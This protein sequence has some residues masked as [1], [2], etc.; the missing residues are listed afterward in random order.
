MDDR[1]YQME[2][3]TACS[4]DALYEEVERA[5]NCSKE[6]ISISDIGSAVRNCPAISMIIKE[7]L[8]M[9]IRLPEEFDILCFKIVFPEMNYDDI[10][11]AMKHFIVDGKETSAR[12]LGNNRS[13]VCEKIKRLVDRY[14]QF[15][16]V[17]GIKNGAMVPMDELSKKIRS[18]WS[19]HDKHLEKIKLRRKNEGFGDVDAIKL[20]DLYT[21]VWP[22]KNAADATKVMDELCRHNQV[23]KIGDLFYIKSKRRRH[24]YE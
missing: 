13:R 1:E 22:V 5:L 23:A 4:P 14:P 6:I 15:A 17:F 7:F 8:R 9:R 12:M 10:V 24:A 18:F 20:S 16:T 2:C 21:N 11:A 3:D 19:W